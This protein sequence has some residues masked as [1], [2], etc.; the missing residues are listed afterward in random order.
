[1]DNEL[2]IGIDEVGRGAWA[3]PLVVGAVGLSKPI[4]GVKDSKLLSKSS[5]T[6]LTSTIYQ[7]AT[8]VGL[9][10]VSSGEIDMLGLSQAMRLGCKRAIKRLDDYG[11]IIIDGNIN[12]LSENAKA[13][14]LIKADQSEP[15]VSAA[16]IVAKVARDEFMAEQAKTH[17]K[18]NFEFNVGY[19]TKKHIEALSRWGA[20]PLHRV[21]YK[22]VQ[23][24]LP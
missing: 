20:S 7:R 4:E 13:K 17:S 14:N 21:S 22:P 1:M 5:R 23:A 15:A 8:F 11:S 24:V 12:Y 6:S 19:G 9:G 10:W 16:S 2:I 3:G 18:Y